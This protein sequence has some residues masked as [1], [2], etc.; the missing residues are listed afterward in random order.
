MLAK[1]PGVYPGTASV[2]SQMA[3]LQ[4]RVLRADAA[5]VSMDTALPPGPYIF[6]ALE[7]ASGMSSPAQDVPFTTPAFMNNPAW[8]HSDGTPVEGSGSRAI[9]SGVLLQDAAAS[10]SYDGVATPGDTI[11]GM[12]GIRSVVNLFK[13]TE[14]QFHKADARPAVLRKVNEALALVIRTCDEAAEESIRTYLSAAYEYLVSDVMPAFLKSFTPDQIDRLMKSTRNIEATEG[15]SN[16]CSFC[17]GLAERLTGRRMNFADLIYLARTYSSS[18]DQR[19]LLYDN[20]EFMDWFDGDWNCIDLFQMFD[21]FAKADQITTAFRTGG[22]ELFLELVRLGIVNR[23]SVHAD[24]LPRLVRADIVNVKDGALISSDIPLIADLLSG[25]RGNAIDPGNRTRMPVGRNFHSARGLERYFGGVKRLAH[26][27]ALKF[28]GFFNDI[29]CVPTEQNKMGHISIRITPENLETPIDEKAP[30]QTIDVLAKYGVVSRMHYSDMFDEGSDRYYLTLTNFGGGSKHVYYVE[31]DTTTL[32]VLELISLG[33]DAHQAADFLEWYSKKRRVRDAK[34][35][36]LMHPHRVAM[37]MG[38]IFVL[39]ML[40]LDVCDIVE[41][42][43]GRDRMVRKSVRKSLEGVKGL[44]ARFVA[45]YEE[46]FEECWRNRYRWESEI[47]RYAENYAKRLNIVLKN[48][49]HIS[50][51]LVRSVVRRMEYQLG[52]YDDIFFLMLHLPE[53]DAAHVEKLRRR[54][55]ERIRKRIVGLRK[56]PE[57]DTLLRRF[58]E[59]D[60]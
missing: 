5:L 1:S 43:G 31:Y 44:P 14:V 16:Y 37:A 57:I 50:K 35:I 7:G 19:I 30:P 29:A 39:G 47:D 55:F 48:G 23:L 22:K 15:C 49:E 36:E 42:E 34:L 33:R 3:A 26:A 45:A 46:Y 9:Q 53:A 12:L 17:A 56:L 40:L 60:W 27:V 54:Y 2:Y 21:F 32:E 8:L 4:P 51:A 18:S 38:N 41:M 10:V 20:S 24:N 25:Q 6:R 59:V 52:I 11:T 13:H 58:I 28:G